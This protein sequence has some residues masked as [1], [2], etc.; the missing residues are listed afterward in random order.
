MRTRFQ[1][2][3]DRSR[4]E[5]VLGSNIDPIV[6][7]APCETTI[8]KVWA[9]EVGDVVALAGEGP[10]AP[11]AA[12]RAHEF[13]T[14]ADGT[15][16]TLL[17]VQRPADSDAEEAAAEAGDPEDRGRELVAEVAEEAGIPED[18]YEPTVVVAADVE[19]AILNHVDEYDTVCVG[20]T[21]AGSVAQALF[22]SL[23]ETVGERADATV[24]MVRGPDTSPMSVREAIVKRLSD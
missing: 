5:Y 23:P 20:A 9:D 8:V 12:R 11:V 21:R 17:N 7:R 15:S 14:G 3:I 2:R 18:G 19:T 13:V 24:A 16:L 4:R 22:G 10:H 1:T 6:S